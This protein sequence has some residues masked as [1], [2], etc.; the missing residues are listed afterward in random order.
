MC[1]PSNPFLAV[2]CSSLSAL[3]PL[4]AEGGLGLRCPPL[5]RL[6]LARTPQPREQPQTTRPLL[7]SASR[8][9]PGVGPG[10]KE[11]DHGDTAISRLELLASQGPG[12]ASSQPPGERPL[13]QRIISKLGVCEQTE[14][15]GGS[16]RSCRKQTSLPGQVISLKSTPQA[17]PFP[18]SFR[19]KCSFCP[20]EVPLWLWSRCWGWGWGIPERPWG[21][22]Y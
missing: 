9:G 20:R 8:P 6:V 4:G 2:S 5:P 10:S 21:P 17:L 13:G 19:C 14:L 11:C 3:L 15:R 16:G 18:L 12:A 22:S 7:G 1:C